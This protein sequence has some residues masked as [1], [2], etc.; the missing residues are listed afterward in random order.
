LTLGVPAG[1]TS[2]VASRMAELASTI[3]TGSGIVLGRGAV[4]ERIVSG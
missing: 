1:K 3:I 2:A 4:N